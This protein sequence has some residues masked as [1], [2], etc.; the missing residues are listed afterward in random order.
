MLYFSKEENNIRWPQGDVTKA[1]VAEQLFKHLE[2]LATMIEIDVIRV[3]MKGASK[4]KW[5]EEN[6]GNE[7]FD[8]HKKA[9]TGRLE[10][11]LWMS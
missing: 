10:C 1:N 11:S 3:S 9:A 7:D 8:K 2:T 4:L 6:W 5:L